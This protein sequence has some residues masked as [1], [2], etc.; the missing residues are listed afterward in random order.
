MLDLLLYALYIGPIPFAAAIY[1]REYGGLFTADFKGLRAVRLI[2]LVY[3]L[4]FLV[5]LLRYGTSWFCGECVGEGIME[6]FFLPSLGCAM[7]VFTPVFA[8]SV[9]GT[10]EEDVKEF[11][12]SVIG[13]LVVFH[14]H[15][16]LVDYY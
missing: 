9:F 16:T 14:G 8:N 12:L 15:V 4:F 1:I 10:L 13:A 7:I 2:G 6:M 5:V 3:W 11:G